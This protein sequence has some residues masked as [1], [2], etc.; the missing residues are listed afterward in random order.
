MEVPA[1]SE[2]PS[3]STRSTR[4]GCEHSR[5]GGRMREPKW[6]R[7]FVRTGGHADSADDRG[8]NQ[9]PRCLERRRSPSVPRVRAR[10]R[11]SVGV[12]VS[13]L[14][15]VF[16]VFL[17]FQCLS[18]YVFSCLRF[19]CLCLERSFEN[20]VCLFECSEFDVIVYS[21][22]YRSNGHHQPWLWQ[23]PAT[24]LQRACHAHGGSRRDRAAST[25]DRRRRF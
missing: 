3:V 19:A 10:A 7:G 21:E 17:L 12:F 1:Y 9:A 24:R 5:G 25:G 11:V 2:Y 6:E 8:P 18:R 23:V 13:V 22:L 15:A 16:V 4:A 20:L 14:L